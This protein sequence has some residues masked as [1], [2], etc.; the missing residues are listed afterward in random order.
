MLHLVPGRGS[1][2]DI[3]IVSRSF[4]SLKQRHCNL[5]PTLPSRLDAPASTALSAP[6]EWTLSDGKPSGPGADKTCLL[7]NK[8]HLQSLWAWKRH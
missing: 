7:A 3:D 8:M 4:I 2:S 1:S 6:D 5:V